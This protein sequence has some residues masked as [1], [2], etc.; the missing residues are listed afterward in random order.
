MKVAIARLLSSKLSNGAAPSGP[1]PK[2]SETNFQI[3]DFWTFTI[4]NVSYSIYI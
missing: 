3:E 1:G 4:I 2:S